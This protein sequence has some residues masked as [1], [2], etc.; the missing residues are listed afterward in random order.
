MNTRFEPDSEKF[1]SWFT[2]L[3]PFTKNNVPPKDQK[4]LIKYIEDKMNE[5]YFSKE[6][7]HTDLVN[8]YKDVSISPKGEIK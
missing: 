3:I 7:G 5:S 4:E 8:S 6:S 1:Y 2:N